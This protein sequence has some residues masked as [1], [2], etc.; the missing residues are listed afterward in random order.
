MNAPCP[1]ELLLKGFSIDSRTVK[2]GELFCAISGEK[3]D[4]HDHL[5]EAVRKGAAAVL[6]ERQL[7]CSIPFV[8]V[9]SVQRA[10]QQAAQ[11]AYAQSRVKGIAVTGSNGKTTTK[12]F[13]YQL[14][15]GAF[16]T[17]GNANSQLGL[18]LALLNGLKGSESYAVLEMGMSTAGEIAKLVQ[19][20]PPQVAVIT[21]VSYCHAENFKGLKEIA[22]AKAEIFSQSETEHKLYHRPIEKLIPE[23]VKGA[24]PFELN[25]VKMPFTLLSEKDGLYFVDHG[26]RHL[27]QD[28]PFKEEHLL[29][30]LLAALAAVCLAG[31]SMDKT[32]ARV[33][34]LKLPEKRFQPVQ[35]LGAL[36]INDAYNASPESM[37]AA[38]KALPKPLGRGKRIGV[39][40]SMMELGSFSEE[41]HREVGKFALPILDQLICHG[42]ECKPLVDEWKKAGREAQIT[43]DFEELKVWVEKSVVKDDVVLLKGS[44]SKQLWKLIEL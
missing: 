19:I 7:H 35:K 29:H 42:I 24:V 41:C 2:E 31:A 14:L 22:A 33:S 16:K 20:A 12:E 28:L 4:G 43:N 38:L 8:V 37:K 34:Q 13:I 18:P 17:P 26:K 36:Y 11:H 15:E 40:G 3:H 23:M 21:T 5:D 25:N 30:D 10:L 9:N 32:L 6:V 44:N 27:L 1:K 39:L